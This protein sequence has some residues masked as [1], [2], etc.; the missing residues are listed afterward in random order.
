[1]GL[2]LEP[3]P[4]N[5]VK[6]KQIAL[7]V[8]AAAVLMLAVALFTKSWLAPADPLGG[9]MGL[10]SYHITFKGETVGEGTN[11][12]LI[13]SHNERARKSDKKGPAFWIAGY[14]TLIVGLLAIAALT[15][16]G[17]LVARGGF[18]LG[19]IAPSS[20]ALLTLFLVLVLGAVFLATN[21][22]RGTNFQLGASWSFW[23]FGAGVV[24][25]IVAA[26]L[27]NKFKPADPELD[28]FAV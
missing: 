5:P 10:R 16:A 28:P 27:L 12:A 7:A 2:N 1:M 8:T 15:T 19:P 11:K 18:F 24:T 13:A 25:G 23:L 14:G 20:V 22:T 26:Q 3:V 17:V 6:K 4:E 9:G 21:P